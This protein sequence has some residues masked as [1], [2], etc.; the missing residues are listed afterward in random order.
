MYS[1]KLGKDE[2]SAANLQKLESIRN[3]ACRRP[4]REAR[5]SGEGRGAGAVVGRAGGDGN[6]GKGVRVLG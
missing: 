2:L 4:V 3:P 6:D 1:R 5:R